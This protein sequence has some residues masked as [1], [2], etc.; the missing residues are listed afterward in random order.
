[1]DL[2]TNTLLESRFDQSSP[3]LASDK[4]FGW[5]FQIGPLVQIEFSWCEDSPT[6]SA[7]IAMSFR[8]VDDR[9]GWAR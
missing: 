4:P 2:G 9:K 6:K 3:C 1:M 8:G 7:C 5:T